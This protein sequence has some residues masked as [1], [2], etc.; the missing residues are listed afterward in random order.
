RMRTSCWS[1]LLAST[2]R[3]VSVWTTI[4][5][6]FPDP[7]PVL[8]F[9]VPAHDEEASIVATVESIVASAQGHAF[10]VVVV[11]DASSDRPRELATAAGAGV[12]SVQV[13]QLAGARTAGA[14][15]A[16]GDVFVL[17][18]A[19]TR[20]SKAVV[21]GV[22]AAPTNGAVGGGAMVRFD[23]PMPLWA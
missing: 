23:Q 1:T 2:K 4:R 7:H 3:S 10:E 20:I 14:A 21:A 15:A 8:S 16:R 18:D 13:R 6:V 12:V 17:V 22:L 9:I 19:D 5:A 11:D